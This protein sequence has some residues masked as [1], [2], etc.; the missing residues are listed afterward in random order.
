MEGSIN[1]EMETIKQLG[2]TGSLDR[3]LYIKYTSWLSKEIQML[4]P[5]GIA[6]LTTLLA[7]E[8]VAGKGSLASV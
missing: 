6:L 1:H 7:K 2:V 8:E 4:F 5:P 3:T